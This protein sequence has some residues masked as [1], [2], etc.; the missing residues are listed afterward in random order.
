MINLSPRFWNWPTS[1]STPNRNGN[2]KGKGEQR[3]ASPAAQVRAELAREHQRAVE[4]ARHPKA[5]TAGNRPIDGLVGFGSGSEVMRQPYFTPAASPHQ[6]AEDAAA[7]QAAAAA[8]ASAKHQQ[9]LQAA[10]GQTGMPA[11]PPA[12]WAQ[13]DAEADADG[14]QQQQQQA[15]AAA[16]SAARPGSAA[17]DSAQLLEDW[18]TANVESSAA[19]HGYETMPMTQSKDARATLLEVSER[20][21][22]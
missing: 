14:Q 5:G 18:H 17:S 16:V 15:A 11:P 8:R 3:A 20:T 12:L 6:V 1:S 10:Q 7:R 4:T 13:V 22:D 21:Q 9:L 19:N 2:G